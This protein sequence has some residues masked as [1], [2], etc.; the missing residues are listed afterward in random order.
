MKLFLD[1][2]VLMSRTLRDWFAI[3]AI[4]SGASPTGPAVELRVSEDVLSEWQYRLRRRH[5]DA[6]EQA[7]GGLRRQFLSSQP[8][9]VIITGYQAIT[10][11]ELADVDDRH[12]I[13]AATHDRVDYLVT[14][15]AGVLDASDVVEPEPISADDMLCLLA[16]RD[17]RLVTAVTRLQLKYWGSKED[18]KPL[19]VALGDAGATEFAG[20]IQRVVRGLAKTGLY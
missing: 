15:D 7:I 4:K 2:N 17:Q 9:S 16:E 5:P 12:V 3:L 19:H 10:V 11:P 18:S 20:V 13:A 6:P 14:D 1:A 8:E